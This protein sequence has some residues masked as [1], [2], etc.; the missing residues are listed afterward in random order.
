MTHVEPLGV[1]A[2]DGHVFVV[3][4]SAGYESSTLQILEL[5]GGALASRVVVDNGG[6]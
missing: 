3:V 4:H 5:A 2:L 6:C 1:I